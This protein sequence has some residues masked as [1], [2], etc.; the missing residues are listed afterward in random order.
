[1]SRTLN[2]CERNYPAIEKEATAVVEA[3]RKWSHFLKAYVHSDRGLSFISHE[4]KVFLMSV[5]LQPANLHH[6]TLKVILNANASIKPF[7][8]LLNYFCTGNLWPRN[9]GRKSY[10]RRFMPFGLW[11]A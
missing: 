10:P 9:S 8:E 2:T 7:G 11:C 1:M 6:I 3:V 5:G 4:V